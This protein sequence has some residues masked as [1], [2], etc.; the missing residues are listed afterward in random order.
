MPYLLGSMGVLA[1]DFVILG[2]FVQYHKQASEKRVLEDGFQSSHVQTEQGLH[3][4]VEQYTYEIVD[5][6]E[7][8]I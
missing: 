4:E 6:E 3:S 1:L 2:Q 7:L 8:I 5:E